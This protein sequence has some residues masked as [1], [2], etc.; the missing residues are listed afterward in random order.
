MVK[1]SKQIELEWQY[2]GIRVNFKKKQERQFNER[3]KVGDQRTHRYV[4][5]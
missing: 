4:H 1:I 3:I 2:K 5:R